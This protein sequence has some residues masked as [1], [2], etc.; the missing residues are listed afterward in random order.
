MVSNAPTNMKSSRMMP[1]LLKSNIGSSP[2][3]QSLGQT[4]WNKLM[5]P[6]SKG[7]SVG[8]KVM[9]FFKDTK[10]AQK[11]WKRAALCLLSQHIDQGSREYRFKE[12]VKWLILSF[13]T[14]KSDVP[15]RGICWGFK[16]EKIRAL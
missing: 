2:V 3:W 5:K 11:T 9:G 6:K 7:Y 8:N 10:E 15:Y 1:Q 12:K 4:L 14:Y 16:T 13:L